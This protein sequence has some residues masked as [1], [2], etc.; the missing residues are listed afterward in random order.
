MNEKMQTEWDRALGSAAVDGAKWYFIRKGTRVGALDQRVSARSIKERF[1][2]AMGIIASGSS[3]DVLEESE[4]VSRCAGFTLCMLGDYSI[5]ALRTVASPIPPD[6]EA[7]GCVGTVK[8]RV[9]AL[10]VSLISYVIAL[11]TMSR[12]N[13]R[14]MRW[15]EMLP[16][17]VL[18]EV[19]FIVS[20]A[21]GTG[22][23]AHHALTEWICALFALCATAM[24]HQD[25]A[26]A[27]TAL[28]LLDLLKAG[29]V[30]LYWRRSGR[31]E[32]ELIIWRLP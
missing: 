15:Q 9:L 21:T 12:H 22:T 19:R 6:A 1:H 16:P 7:V 8:E 18:D 10:E 23:A 27:R 14:E 4:L 5:P 29:F 28:D 17:S 32:R 25:V 11:L 31:N 30:P 13:V 3:Y 24:R 26:L 2:D 20:V